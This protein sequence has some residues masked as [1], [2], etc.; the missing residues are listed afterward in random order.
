MAFVG[1]SAAAHADPDSGAL[2]WRMLA[3][4]CVGVWF[5]RQWLAVRHCGGGIDAA[6][7]VYRVEF[8]GFPDC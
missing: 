4:V 2:V 5:G 3:G 6:S 1:G 8:R 7:F